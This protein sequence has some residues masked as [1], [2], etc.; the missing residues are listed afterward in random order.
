MSAFSTNL[1]LEDD[2]LPL[3]TAIHQGRDA[4]LL[5][6]HPATRRDPAIQTAASHATLRARRAMRHNIRH[7]SLPPSA[8]LKK[9]HAARA[10]YDRLQELKRR[11]ENKSNGVLRFDLA[12]AYYLVDQTETQWQIAKSR[13]ATEVGE[14]CGKLRRTGLRKRGD[15]SGSMGASKSIF[16]R[17]GSKIFK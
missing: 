15:A 8:W 4:A 3:Q 6:A 11:P 17:R 1:T 5:A 7:L 16:K 14:L 2:I 9:L 12:M 13:E 10:D